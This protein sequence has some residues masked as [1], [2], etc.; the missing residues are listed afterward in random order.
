M[1]P[2]SRWDPA[3]RNRAGRRFAAICAI[4][5][6]FP[7]RVTDLRAAPRPYEYSLVIWN[8]GQGAWSTFST[9]RACWHFDM[10]GERA[11]WAAVEAE[12]LGKQNRVSFS[13]WDLD[14][15]AFAAAAARRLPGLCIAHR[16]GG[17]APNPRK[18]RLLAGLPDCVGDADL[19]VR[20][21]TRDA[22]VRAR[23]ARSKAANETSR[24]FLVAGFAIAPGD[25]PRAQET[26]WSERL[27]ARD[28]PKALLLGHHG[29]R[30]S[31]GAALLRR[32]GASLEMAIASA[33]KSRYGH[34]HAQVAAALKAKGIALIRTEIWGHVRIEWRPPP[35]KSQPL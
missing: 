21:L 22:D 15:V 4:A 3:E 17:D 13:H 26:I 34:P 14:H 6:L 27:S 30:T 33:R 24:V 35:R 1:S 29:S 23:G 5:L 11:D 32:T 2:W 12:C 7:A 9:P 31:T 10:G 8:V 16:P 20:E 18:A 25:S 19:A 28:R